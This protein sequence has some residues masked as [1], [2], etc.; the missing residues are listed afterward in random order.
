MAMNVRRNPGR[1][2][3]PVGAR[4]AALEALGMVERGMGPA[5]ALAPLTAALE[6]RDQ[7]FAHLLVLTTLRRR[8]QIDALLKT[9][10][11]RPLPRAA[12]RVHDLLRL[13]VAQILFLETQPH[14]AV[15]TTVDLA[16]AEPGRFAP[17]VNAVLRRVV[18]ERAA[19]TV[20][21]N[22]PA[23]NVPRWLWQSWV[24]AYGAATAQAIAVAHAA[25]P[26]LDLS[27]KDEASR[28]AWQSALNAE[29]MPAGSLRLRGAGRIEA[30]PGFA[31]G[32]WWVQDMA[33]ALPARLLL[34][35]LARQGRGHNASL[36]DLCAAPGGKT[37][38][39]AAA[40]HAVTAIDIAADRLVIVRENLARLKLS[41]TCLATDAR[42]WKPAAPMDGVLLDAPCSATGTIRRHPDIAWAKSATQI[43]AL[44]DL[45]ASLLD[46]A[47]EIVAP[48]GVLVYAVCSLQPEEGERQADAF[49]RRMGMQFQR[50][51]VTADVVDG[52]PCL[53]SRGDLRT[54]PCH[55]AEQGGMDGFF[56]ARFVRN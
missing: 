21:A 11:Q 28:D 16:S 45:Q 6:P 19:L 12:A 3:T 33:A 27:L 38:Q 41:A 25:E 9:C 40:G 51:P 39:L 31:E 8:G 50:M 46:A 52:L 47:A 34:D 42:R 14:A 10:L 1:A 43:Q 5:E 48:G 35:G 22:D 49:L 15:D 7:G 20:F 26:P 29:V 18:R 32:A 53:D 4:A 55:L 23:I 17:L 56:A 44:C 36:V 24:S 2:T 30:L 13:G 54:L 37:A